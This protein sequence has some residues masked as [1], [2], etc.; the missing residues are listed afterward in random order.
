MFCAAKSLEIAKLLMLYSITKPFAKVALA[1]YF[2]KINISHRERIPV[3]K[4]VLL[5]ANH[6][7]AFIEP[8]ILSCWLE[9]PLSFLARGDLYLNNTFIRKIYD[10][11]RMTPVFRID[12]AG[13]GQ[14]K[15]N[16]ESFAKCYEALRQNR[17]LMIL[18]EG[19]TKHEKRLRPLM[20][21]TARIVFGALELY[22]DLDIYIVP[23]GVNYT[24]SDRFRSDV[25]IDFGEPIRV[26]DYRE[27]YAANGARAVNEV[28]KELAKRLY[29]RVIHIQDPADDGW[30][31]QLL[32]VARHNRPP[33]L[34]PLFATD[35]APLRE[36]KQLVETV[37]A[38]SEEEKL[39]LRSKVEAYFSA[40]GQAGVTDRGLMDHTSYSVGSALLLGLGWV[41]YLVGYALNVLPL[42]LGSR[43]AGKLAKTVEFRASVAIIAT[44]AIYL[45]YWVLWLVAALVVGKTWLIAIALVMPIV[46]YFALIYRDIDLRWKACQKASTLDDETEAKLLRL[47]EQIG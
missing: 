39:V 2:R 42:W 35:D 18:S 34:L 43:L 12:D 20:K 29:E 44:M 15:T 24:D 38:M 46:G 16:Y 33:R 45:I 1:T 17:T 4:P 36:E 19:R 47:R 6:P 9:Q 22:P 28:T 31:E 30:V 27:T 26:A 32:T 7:T 11:Y 10:G 23:V 41:P 40:L 21:G 13:F 37:N 8:C 14:L 5:A 3:G 25:M